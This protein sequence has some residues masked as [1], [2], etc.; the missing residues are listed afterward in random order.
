[1]EWVEKNQD[2][3]VLK[4]DGKHILVCDQKILDSDTSGEELFKKAMKM[5]LDEE[6]FVVLSVGSA[7]Q[8]EEDSG[9]WW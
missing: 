2:S 7:I 9:I 5:L 3:I 6:S 8:T 4:Y 1:M